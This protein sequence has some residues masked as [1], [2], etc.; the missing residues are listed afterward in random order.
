VISLLNIVVSDTFSPSQALVNL[1]GSFFIAFGTGSIGGIFW[2]V[3]RDRF[4][5]IETIF[6]IPALVCIL[7]GI[8]EILEG[9]GAIA[10]FVFGIMLGNLGFLEQITLNG[11]QYFPKNHF[12][13]EEVELFTQLV[14]LLK[15]FFFIYIGISLKFVSMNII[16]FCLLVIFIIHLFRIPAVMVTVS[17]GISRF[18]MQV[19]CGLVP[20][21]LASAVLVSLPVQYGITGFGEYQ[22]VIFTIIIF[23]IFS[24]TIFAYI[25]QKKTACSLPESIL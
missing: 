3:F 10:V 16:L 9:S 14:D 7:Y 1:G 15:T 24:S 22:P 8:T 13:S 2:T 21:G 6:T 5:K 12:R 18:D 4:K 25:F 17:S 23:S 19:I 20:K 11:I